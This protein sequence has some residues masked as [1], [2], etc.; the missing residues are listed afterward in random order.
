MKF[1]RKLFAV[2]LFFCLSGYY[3]VAQQYIMGIGDYIDYANIDRNLNR[4]ENSYANI[5]GS[6][7]LFSN[8]KNGQIKLKD[9][10]I[11]EGPLR[12]DIYADQIEFRT[13]TGDIFAV[14]NPETIDKVTLGDLQLKCF[15]TINGNSLDGIFELLAEGNYILFEKHVVILKDP[16]PPK[17]YVEPKPATFVKKKSEYLV[18][19]PKGEFIPIANKK[20]FAA[21]YPG[22]KALIEKFVKENKIKISNKE[23]VVELV[24]FL[25]K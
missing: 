21:I 18:M 7:F 1:T 22:K 19:N 5:Q 23:D 20:D 8:F 10:K 13:S 16:V 25:N 9:G 12:Y 3:G 17:P 2:V 11:Y 14:K 24:N 4:N 6:P 15:S